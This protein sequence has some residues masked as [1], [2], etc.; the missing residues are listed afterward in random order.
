MDKKLA[1]KELKD[2]K[3]NLKDKNQLKAI[4]FVIEILQNMSD[5]EILENAS[6]CIGLTTNTSFLDVYNRLKD[7]IKTIE[8]ED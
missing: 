4:Q 7:V 6:E 1:I 3:K 5:L 8:G 2:I